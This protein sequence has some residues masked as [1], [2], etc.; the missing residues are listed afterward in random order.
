VWLLRPQVLANIEAAQRQNRLYDAL[1]QGTVAL[2]ALQ[3]VR[4]LEKRCPQHPHSSTIGV[5]HQCIVPACVHT[6]IFSA[7]RS[8]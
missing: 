3:K 4:P 5:A 6:A 1:K 8:S 2:K 7:E